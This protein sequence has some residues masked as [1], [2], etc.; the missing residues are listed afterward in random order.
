MRRQAP[1][2]EENGGESEVKEID[3]KRT[4]LFT[5]VGRGVG[6]KPAPRT[7]P[8]AKRIKRILSS[9]SAGTKKNPLMKEAGTCGDWLTDPAYKQEWVER[10]KRRFMRM[11]EGGELAE[12][13]Q[14]FEAMGE[15]LRR[16]RTDKNLSRNEVAE[17]IGVEASMLCFLE[18]GWVERQE[19]QNVIDR[20]AEA[21]GMDVSD[22]KRDVG[23]E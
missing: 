3:R 18:S 23:I 7:I 13:Q 20:W 10:S 5:Y 15:E 17:Q 6:I 9:G 2:F 16:L 4:S 21:L 11:L 1:V 22:Y 12:E 14:K 8:K 19:L